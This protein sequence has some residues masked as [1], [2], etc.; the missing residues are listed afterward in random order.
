MAAD[1]T[2]TYTPD[3]GHVGGDSFD[4]VV[5]DGTATDTGTVTVTVTGTAGGQP[6][7]DTRITAAPRGTVRSAEATVRFVA[8]GPGAGGATFECSLD[9]SA[10][11]ACTSPKVY[12]GLDDGTHTVRVRAVTAAG[13]DASPDTTTWTVDRDGPRIRRIR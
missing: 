9:G 8:T 13:T 11:Q 3:A 4:Y 5:T 7:P 10:Y 2:V 6:V 12:R 1:G